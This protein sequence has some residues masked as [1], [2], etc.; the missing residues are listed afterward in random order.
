MSISWLDKSQ[1]QLYPNNRLGKFYL[2]WS[3]KVIK[4]IKSN[5]NH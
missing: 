3:D 5:K 4:I 2:E 1:K